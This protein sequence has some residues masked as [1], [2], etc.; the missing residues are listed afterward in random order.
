M[1]VEGLALLRE[2]GP[3]AFEDTYGAYFVSGWQ[4]GAALK[5][6]FTASTKSSEKKSS[7]ALKLRAAYKAVFVKASGSVGYSASSESK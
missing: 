4:L 7:L 1:S 2:D 3:D 6:H 5:I